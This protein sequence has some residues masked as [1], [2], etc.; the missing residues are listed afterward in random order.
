MATLTISHYIYL[1]REQRYALHEGNKL[2][3]TGVS[4]PVWFKKGN[5]SEPAQEIFCKYTISNDSSSN[6][7]IVPTT[8]GYEINLPQKLKFANE[9]VPEETQ[10]VV[11]VYLGTSERLLDIND[12]GS[13]WL[14]FRQ[15]SKIQQGTNKFN[16][17][18]FVEIKPI[19]LLE[20]TLS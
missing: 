20:D 13:E 4:V 2:E 7:S 16:V 17:V 6:R 1:T 14:E 12:G 11:S 8:T 18:H 10:V 15:F 19:E 3:V 9:S 5:T